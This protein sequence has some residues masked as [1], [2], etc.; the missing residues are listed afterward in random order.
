MVTIHMLK[1]FHAMSV[2]AKTNAYDFYNGIVQFMDGSGLH[3]HKSRYQE[4]T[5]ATQCY[6]HLKMTKRGGRG[7]DPGGIE[8][9]SEGSLA[10]ECPA[11]P[12][13][14]KNLPE[15]WD[16][17]PA[18]MKF[19]YALLLAI[20]TNFK[21]KMKNHNYVD[22]EFAPG[23]S[24]FVPERPYQDHLAT[25]KDEEE[26]KNCDSTFAA[27]D[28]ANMPGQKCFA[29]NGVGAVVCARHGFF[30]PNGVGDL[31]RGE[32]YV[33]M[34]FLLLMTISIVGSL[35]QMLV[36]S[37]DITC[38]F[39]KNF[40]KYSNNGMSGTQL[41]RSL[42]E[43]VQMLTEQ[44]TRYNELKETFPTAVI[45]RW[46]RMITLWDA[47]GSQPNPYEEAVSDSPIAGKMCASSAIRA[48]SPAEGIVLPCDASAAPSTS[49]EEARQASQGV[50][51]V[52]E[53]TSGTFLSVGMELQEQQ[54]LLRGKVG[55]TDRATTKKKVTLQDKQNALHHR[56]QAWHQVQ[57]LYMP[58]VTTL[59]P[60]ATGDGSEGQET[61]Q[62]SAS[63]P[64][65][66]T[67]LPKPEFKKLWMPSDLSPSQRVTGILPGLVDKELCLH[68]AEAEDAL[69][70]ICRLIHIHLGLC[71]YKKKQVNGP[72][73]KRNTR[74]REVISK[75]LAKRDRQ[76]ECYNAARGAL[77]KLQSEPD[78]PWQA[79]LLPLSRSD[80]VDPSGDDSEDDNDPGQ[81][82]K[83]ALE[84][85][86]HKAL[87][88][89]RK[90]VPWIWCTPRPDARDMP[91]SE[92]MTEDEIHKSMRVTYAKARARARRWKEEIELLA[93]EMRRTLVYLHWK[94]AWWYAKRD[95]RPDASSDIKSGLSMWEPLLKDLHVK[96]EFPDVPELSEVQDAPVPFTAAEDDI[97]SSDES[98]GSGDEPVDEIIEVWSQLKLS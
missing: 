12:H 49:K 45:G 66:E 62:P 52:H 28:H 89:G 40:Q 3:E 36:I 58:V 29:I 75:F 82:S 80:L 22:L 16:S 33:S 93:E 76:F 54:R 44:Q 18:H 26:M 64:S 10:V 9:T 32:R 81:K 38:Q 24:Y 7:H 61:A 21:L 57:R 65:E 67:T 95:A 6:R 51:S 71:H 4:F 88:E 91:R 31:P 17:V 86:R 37:Y 53:M 13:P 87:G 5:H 63:V 50:L 14:G 23:W 8:S 42:K 68:E 92:G 39:S 41:S 74:A 56:I 25:H 2:Q 35:W 11:C 73:Q 77:D 59:L 43:A 46:E 19:L 98:G 70:E 83:K 30:Q 79:R 84:Q 94:Q 72:S 85:C 55:A 48:P 20:D 60:K 1:L 96:A 90:E 15:N 34:G 78:A 69:H 27:I 97:M 47:D